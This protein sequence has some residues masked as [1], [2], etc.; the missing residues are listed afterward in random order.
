MT[1]TPTVCAFKLQRL[2][3]AELVYNG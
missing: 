1:M 3:Q 2:I